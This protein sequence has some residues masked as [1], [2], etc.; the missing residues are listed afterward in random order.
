MEEDSHEGMAKSKCLNKESTLFLHWC[1]VTR[2]FGAGNASG[3][4][5]VQ[6]G[7]ALLWAREASRPSG[8]R[9][10]PG[11]RAWVPTSVFSKL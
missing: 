6:E 8:C 11:T 5:A 1:E 10:A 3:G 9:P 2:G 7:C 4:R